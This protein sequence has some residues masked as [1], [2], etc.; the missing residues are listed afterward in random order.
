MPLILETL[1]ADNESYLT[2]T[3]CKICHEKAN[4]INCG[5]ICCIGCKSFYLRGRK[6]HQ[7]FVCYYNLICLTDPK[8]IKKCQYCRWKTC[9]NQGMVSNVSQNTLCTREN[10]L[11]SSQ[12]QKLELDQLKDHVHG[13]YIEVVREWDSHVHRAKVIESCGQKRIYTFNEDFMFFINQ[14]NMQCYHSHTRRLH[15][16]IQKLPGF[17]DFHTN[18]L[19][20]IMNTHFFTIMCLTQL[21]LYRNK[22]FYY[23]MN[24]DIPFNR[25]VFTALFSEKVSDC[26][27]N[28]FSGLKSMEFTEKE[29][30]LLIPFVLSSIYFNLENKNLMK[31]R[32]EYYCRALFHE[33]KLN[34]RTLEFMINFAQF[35]CLGQKMNKMIMDVS[36]N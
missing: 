35:V 7:K 28:F 36:T 14:E 4:S 31:E 26:I 19:K 18:D 3:K 30:G 20:I 5:V 16:I 9:I 34:K 1:S 29:L 33:F 13:L 10:N 17:L 11:T 21:K 12:S 24:E 32:Y 27:F 25:D 2:H 6:K 22:D 15:K 23:M 8:K